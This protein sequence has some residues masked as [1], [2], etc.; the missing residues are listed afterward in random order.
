MGITYNTSLNVKGALKVKGDKVALEKDLTTL[1]A[2]VTSLKDTDV[3]KLKTDVEALET[4]VTNVN[5]RIDNLDVSDSGTGFVSAVT[6]SDGKIT[7]TKKAIAQSDVTGLSTALDAKLS[8][9]EAESTYATKDSVASLTKATLFIGIS[10]TEIT[11]NGTEKPTI[12]GTSVTPETGNITIYNSVEFIYANGKWN[13]FG[14]ANSYLLSGAEAVEDKDIADGAISQKKISGLVTALA[15]KVETSTYNAKIATIEGNIAT[16]TTNISAVDTKATDAQTTANTAKTNAA[17]AQTTAD[18]A[19]TN[20]ATAQA[21]AEAAK[22]A[23]DA[24]QA[25]ADA[26]AADIATLKAVVNTKSYTNTSA[27]TSTSTEEGLSVYEVTFAH[28]LATKDV[29]VSVYYNNVLAYVDV[30]IVDANT[31]KIKFL[32]DTATTVAANS[33]KIVV[34]K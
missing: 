26:N 15:A 8:K 14:D 1:S 11:D 28:N 6:Q 29:N 30:T 22:E 21:A 9:T 10:T 33:I 19:K 3:A 5:T 4:S 32:E 12:D 20:A 16:N 25:D 7:V 23:A 27:L 2:T 31:V 13:K 18:T 24:A 17:T 34:Q